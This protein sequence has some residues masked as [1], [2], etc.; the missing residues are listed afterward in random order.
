VA[1]LVLAVLVSVLQPAPVDAGSSW[2]VSRSPSS[3]TVSTV[4]T[5]DHRVVNT[6]STAVDDAIGCVTWTIPDSFD[7]TMATVV[8]VSGGHAW[9]V[10]VVEGNPSVVTYRAATASDRIRAGETPNEYVEGSIDVIP[11]TVGSYSWQVGAYG[12]TDC[13][14]SPTPTATP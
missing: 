9:T 12:G 4:D 2:S 7:I 11:S 3:L 1:T 6:G 14:S 5:V 13:T 10:S 8:S